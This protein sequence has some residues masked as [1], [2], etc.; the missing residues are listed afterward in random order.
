MARL[1]RARLGNVPQD[2]IVSRVRHREGNIVV[3][4]ES[5]AIDLAL[6]TKLAS[7]LQRH[8][9]L[10]GARVD[11]FNRRYLHRNNRSKRE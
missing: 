4:G 5:F 8:L 9:H 11:R 10:S 2:G 1:N 6:L 7:I 3:G